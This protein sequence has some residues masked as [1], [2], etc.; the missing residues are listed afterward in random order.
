M[1][2]NVPPREGNSAEYGSQTVQ[3]T[4]VVVLSALLEALSVQN[5]N[6][7]LPLY[8]WSVLNAVEI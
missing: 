8:M 4:V 6:L 2:L 7:T 5:D 3:Y 1:F